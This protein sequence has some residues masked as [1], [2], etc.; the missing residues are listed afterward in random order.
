MKIRSH[1]LVVATI[2]AA[3]P[4]TANAQTAVNSTDPVYTEQEDD[5]EFPLGLLGLLGLAGLL[6]L[7][8]KDDQNGNRGGTTDRR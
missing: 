1:A 7:K 6:G 3:T 4:V 5:D 8:R 2:L